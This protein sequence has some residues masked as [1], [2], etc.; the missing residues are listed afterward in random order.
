MSFLKFLLVIA[1]IFVSFFA[2]YGCN[3]NASR[4]VTVLDGYISGAIVSDSKGQIAVEKNSLNGLYRFATTPVYPIKSTGGIIVDTG[5]IFDIDMIAYRGNIIS[6]ISTFIKNDDNITNN[7][8]QSLGII[9]DDELL[10]NYIASNNTSIAK[11]SAMLYAVLKDAT[12]KQ[13]FQNRLKNRVSNDLFDDAIE[14][15][16]GNSLIITYINNITNFNS[17]VK[18]ME[19]FLENDKKNLMHKYTSIYEDELPT[20]QVNN[21]LFAH[22]LNADEHDWDKWIISDYLVGWNVYFTSVSPAASIENR[23]SELADYINSQNI[24]D[25]SMIAVGHSM[26]GLDLHYIISRGHENSGSKYYEAAKKIHKVYTIASPHKGN[27]FADTIPLSDAIVDLGLKNMQ[28]FNKDYPYTTFE[29]D[30]RKIELMALRFE[31]ATGMGADGIVSVQNQSLNGAPHSKE[32]YI[33]KHAE[34]AFDCPFI[35]REQ[36]QEKEILNDIILANKNIASQTHDI[37]FYEGNDCTQDEKGV[38]SSSSESDNHC[39]SSIGHSHNGTCD[40][41]EIRSV[42]IF[43]GVQKNTIISVYDNNNFSVYDDWTVINVGNKDLKKA[44]CINSFETS[45]LSSEEKEAGISKFYHKGTISPDGDFLDGKISS[46]SIKH[47]FKQTGEVFF[48]EGKN[49]EQDLKGYYDT[50]GTEVHDN[51]QESN[52]CDNDEIKSVLIFPSVENN[53]IIKLYDD[54]KGSLSATWMY[55]NRGDQTLDVPFCINDLV[56]NTNSAEVTKGIDVYYRGALLNEL[57][58]QVSYIKITNKKDDNIVFFEGED[59]SQNVELSLDSTK[60]YSGDSDKLGFQ[61][62]EI[63]SMLL[64]AGVKKGKVI[65]LYDDKDGKTSQSYGPITDIYGWAKI[66]V[67]KDLDVPICIHNFD[68]EKDLVH[69]DLDRYHADD[70]LGGKISRIVVENN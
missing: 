51:C 14:D 64:Q 19:L 57:N 41:D 60:T 20:E 6:P 37:V 2:L 8:K 58:G 62:D 49:C 32:I 17:D 21:I 39:I 12:L 27:Q 66:T 7:L 50:L 1:S 23:A 48:Y 61:N 24:Q 65:K 54:P 34:K 55:I 9:D 47:S 5:Q 10:G 63:K 44:V 42:K 52:N 18:E 56:H 28:Q 70:H 25:D 38:F 22:G 45:S 59:C 15:A 3:N 68:D 4:D 43:P 31:C 35:V 29:I 16:S 40:D 33:G 11:V 67:K 36:D 26:G 46:I 30:E 53:T 69:I 13:N